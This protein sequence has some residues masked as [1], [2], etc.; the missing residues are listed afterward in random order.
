[1]GAGVETCVDAGKVVAAPSMR[2]ALNGH[3]AAG[4]GGIS[5]EL[6]WIPSSLVITWLKARA[7]TAQRP[8]CS[9]APRVLSLRARAAWPPA[10][11]RHACAAPR[12]SV[13][14]AASE[15]TAGC[16]SR[17]ATRPCPCRT[18]RSTRQT[19]RNGLLRRRLGGRTRA[20]RTRARGDRRRVR[21]PRQRGAAAAHT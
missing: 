6:V 7:H 16:R 18:P 2:V 1:M 21:W 12:P 8:A 10:G 13:P 3:R 5:T 11:S 4:C 15:S 19:A 20:T 9:L 14:C 17:L